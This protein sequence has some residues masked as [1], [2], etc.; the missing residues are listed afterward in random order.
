VTK[1]TDSSFQWHRLFKTIK[2]LPWSWSYGS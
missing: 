1:K 2:G